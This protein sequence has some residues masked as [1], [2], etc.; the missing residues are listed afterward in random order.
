MQHTPTHTMRTALVGALLASA[1]AAPAAAPQRHEH[2]TARR[3]ILQAS[4]ESCEHGHA[5][6]IVELDTSRVGT[7]GATGDI[8]ARLDKLVEEATKPTSLFQTSAGA[9]SVVTRIVDY[10]T[11]IVYEHERAGGVFKSYYLQ[12]P[13]EYKPERA[14]F[15]SYHLGSAAV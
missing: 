2:A 12:K 11:D 15:K 6:Y 14:V 7:F 10:R 1:A 3:R 4:I 13:I 8:M 9:G 5:G